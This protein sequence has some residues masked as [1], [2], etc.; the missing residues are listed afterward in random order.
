MKPLHILKMKIMRLHGFETR[1]NE[2][3]SSLG[4]EP[5]YNPLTRTHGV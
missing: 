3:V 2:R 5:R 4:F 1:C